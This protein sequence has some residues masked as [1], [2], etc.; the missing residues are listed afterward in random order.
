M[1]VLVTELLERLYVLYND[2][3]QCLR[4]RSVVRKFTPV[5]P[6]SAEADPNSNFKKKKKIQY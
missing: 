1:N 4:V 5:T 3:N 2:R 6:Q